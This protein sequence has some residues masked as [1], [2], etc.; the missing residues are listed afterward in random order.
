MHQ[1]SKLDLFN[2]IASDLLSCCDSG[3]TFLGIEKLEASEV[4]LTTITGEPIRVLGE[5]KV[6]VRY[7]GALYNDMP[8]IVVESKGPALL[9]RDWL[10][11]IRVDWKFIKSLKENKPTDGLIQK[12][13]SLFDGQLGK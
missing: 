11:K 7:H 8:L 1:L 9:G 12:H 5:C 3:F 6:D 4:G 10:S 2:C 13:S